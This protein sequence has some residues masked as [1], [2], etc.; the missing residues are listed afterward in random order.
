M[1]DEKNIP[2]LHG[3]SPVVRRSLAVSLLVVAV[4]LLVFG[5]VLPTVGAFQAKQAHVDQ[6]KETLV[7]YQNVRGMASVYRDRI[8]D[9]QSNPTPEVVYRES[10]P[11]IFNASMQ[12][13][14][15]SLIRSA[16]GQID[17]MQSTPPTI[18]DGRATITVRMSM[19]CDVDVLAKVLESFRQ[20]SKLMNLRNVSIRTADN[21]RSSAKPVV[22]VGWEIEG[23]G[24]VLDEQ[25]A[26]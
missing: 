6:L 25:G 13:D 21:H 22:S 16:G 14:I 20:H 3:F 17:S 5:V 11:A 19:R 23:Y 4:L 2:A 12:S 18:I 1:T 24:R 10:T 8:A 7:R 9:E 26:T 15:R